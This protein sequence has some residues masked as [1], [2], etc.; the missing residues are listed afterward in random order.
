MV[1]AALQELLQ[2]FGIV[3]D[4]ASLLSL[5]PLLAEAKFGS[6]LRQKRGSN[7]ERHMPA[8]WVLLLL[9][10]TEVASSAAFFDPSDKSARRAI[11]EV[12]RAQRGA[13]TG[14]QETVTGMIKLLEKRDVYELTRSVAMIGGLTGTVC[15]ATVETSGKAGS[16]MTAP[17][18]AAL[19]TIWAPRVWMLLVLAGLFTTGNWTEL[20][21]LARKPQVASALRN[22]DIMMRS[23]CFVGVTGPDAGPISSWALLNCIACVARICRLVMYEQL[24]PLTWL[25]GAKLPELPLLAGLGL[26][27]WCVVV[28]TLCLIRRPGKLLSLASVSAPLIGLVLGGDYA[29]PFQP[30]VAPTLQ[31]GAAVVA[32]VSAMLIFMG[33]FPTMISSLIMVQA[34]YAI[35]GIDNA[36][37]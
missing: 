33:G 37:L 25:A 18:V 8:F 31:R 14:F 20:A 29:A 23:V 12:I 10:V 13:G 2:L 27:V 35:H 28:L 7:D 34:I 24:A 22:F 21:K 19:R 15:I 32:A 17:L 5:L 30:F 4:V 16:S 9:L 11:G 3:G 26:E 1:S 36:K 6:L